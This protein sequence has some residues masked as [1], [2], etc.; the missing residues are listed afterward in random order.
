MTWSSNGCTRKDL[1][2]KSD[3]YIGVSCNCDEPSITTL[4]YDD[5]GLFHYIPPVVIISHEQQYTWKTVLE[6]VFYSFMFVLL[7][8]LIAIAWGI[9]EDM[10]SSQE[11]PQ[12]RKQRRLTRLITKRMS[13][14]KQ[15]VPIFDPEAMINVKNGKVQ[16][17]TS[18][19]TRR[20]LIETGNP[21]HTEANG[22]RNLFSNPDTQQNVHIAQ[23]VNTQPNDDHPLK[24]AVPANKAEET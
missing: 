15:V 24:S 4:V 1:K 16:E 17:D 20:A 22:A 3:I 13:M 2:D 6:P 14:A 7:D 11:T 10:K 8:F 18:Q 21:T 12:V 19:P 23:T 9:K 5:Q